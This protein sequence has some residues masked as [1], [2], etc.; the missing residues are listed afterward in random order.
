M[1][2]TM[3]LVLALMVTPAV[4]QETYSF[5]VEWEPVEMEAPFL[6]QI[7]VGLFEGEYTS[8][9]MIES[10]WNTALVVAAHAV[11]WFVAIRTCLPRGEATPLCGDTW[12]L[13]RHEAGSDNY[14]PHYP[15]QVIIVNVADFWLRSG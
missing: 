4:A 15:V 8:T 3:L 1:R 7:G 9:K 14:G 2:L 6:Y 12:T 5:S 10:R 13:M 11:P